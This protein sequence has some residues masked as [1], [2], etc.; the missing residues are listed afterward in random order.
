[1]LR[2]RYGLMPTNGFWTLIEELRTSLPSGGEVEWTASINE[3]TAW[4]KSHDIDANCTIVE[5]ELASAAQ[6]NPGWRWE[7]TREGERFR[8]RPVK[9]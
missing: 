2:T 5:M 7:V 4:L 3:I 8:F 1:M 9:K 6:K